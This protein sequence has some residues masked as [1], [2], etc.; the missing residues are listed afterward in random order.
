MSPETT[1][2]PV[3]P[4]AR[5]AMGLDAEAPVEVVATA[6][7]KHVGGGY[8]LMPDG[9]KVRGRKAAGLE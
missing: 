1:L 9:T 4:D 5:A 6:A 7:P 2:S 8:Y 3:D